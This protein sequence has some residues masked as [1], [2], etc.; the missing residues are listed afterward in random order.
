MRSRRAR[1]IVLFAFLAL[2]AGAVA[3]PAYRVALVGAGFAAKSVCSTVFVSG[4]T[5][6]CARVLEA[7]AQ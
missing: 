3:V 2:A 6:A 1:R 4:R 5:L 7:L